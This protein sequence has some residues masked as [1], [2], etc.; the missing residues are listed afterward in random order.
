MSALSATFRGFSKKQN[1]PIAVARAVDLTADFV[2]PS[3]QTLDRPTL[4]HSCRSARQSGT[5]G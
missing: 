2:H 1:Y 3:W 5:S 4:G